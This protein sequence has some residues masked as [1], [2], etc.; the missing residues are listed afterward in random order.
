MFVERKRQDWYCNG[1]FLTR[2]K[3]GQMHQRP[4]ELQERGEGERGE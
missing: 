2:A 4:R 1:F 3:M